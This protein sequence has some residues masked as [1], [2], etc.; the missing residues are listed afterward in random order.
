[1]KFTGVTGYTMGGFVHVLY[2]IGWGNRAGAV[3]HWGRGLTFTK[4]RPHRAMTAALARHELTG[5]P[6]GDIGGAGRRAG[7]AAG[8][9][10]LQA[11]GKRP[12]PRVRQIFG[13][14]M[15]TPSVK[16]G[17]ASWSSATWSMV[18]APAMHAATV[19]T[20]SAEYSPST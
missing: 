19:C 2:L 3:F 4:N 16:V 9:R 17:N 10:S 20:T 8:A 6:A 12:M 13:A 18:M 7:Q 11:W 14:A 5:R 1:M 15:D